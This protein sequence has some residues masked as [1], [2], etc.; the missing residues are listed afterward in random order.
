MNQTLAEFFVETIRLSGRRCRWIVS[1]VTICSVALLTACYNLYFSWLRAIALMDNWGTP[2]VVA[3]AQEQLVGLWVDSGFI[4]IPLLGIKFH[5]VDGTIIGSI[6]L[7]VLSVWLYYAMRRDNHLI[8]RALTLA[9]D[10]PTEPVTAKFLF[11]GISSL[12]VFALISNNDDPISAVVHTKTDARSNLVRMAFGSMYYLPAITILVLII[13]DALSL[14]AL[15]SA[16]RDGHAM[17][18]AIDL[19]PANWRK[20]ALM[21]AVAIITAT[22]C[23]WLGRQIHRFQSSTILVLRSFYDQKIE[24][25]SPANEPE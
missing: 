10:N 5:V 21:E 16:F 2:P 22:S 14:F 18:S 20:I 8:G 24:L 17:L 12:Q 7:T 25:I 11:Y 13:C 6:G 23:F 9:V 4:S 19:T 15:R 3:K 1:A